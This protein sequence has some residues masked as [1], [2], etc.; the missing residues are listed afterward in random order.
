MRGLTDTKSGMY[1]IKKHADNPYS[2]TLLFTNV[3]VNNMPL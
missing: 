2:V 1:T 3:L